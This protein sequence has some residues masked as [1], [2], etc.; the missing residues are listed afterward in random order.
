MTAYGEEGLEGL[1]QGGPV[2]DGMGL[3]WGWGDDLPRPHHHHTALVCGGPWRI[4]LRP[5]AVA[6]SS[7]PVSP[8]VPVKLLGVIKWYWV[9]CKLI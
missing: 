8:P 1:L 2:Y 5:A 3:A 4:P 6:P 9:W 7:A